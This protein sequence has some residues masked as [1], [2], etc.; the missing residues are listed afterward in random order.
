MLFVFS[1]I[2]LQVCNTVCL[3]LEKIYQKAKLKRKEDPKS[4]IMKTRIR[5]GCTL[6]ISGVIVEYKGNILWSKEVS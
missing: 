2:T 1:S 3:K 5:Q 6:L 4:A